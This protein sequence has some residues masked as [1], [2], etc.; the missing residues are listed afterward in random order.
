MLM[1]W[2]YIF[3]AL[4]HWHQNFPLFQPFVGESN[5]NWGIPPENASILWCHQGLPGIEKCR[6]AVG[7]GASTCGLAN[8]VD[9][10]CWPEEPGVLKEKLFWHPLTAGV[11]E[12]IVLWLIELLLWDEPPELFGAG[13]LWCVWLAVNRGGWLPAVTPGVC[14]AA[15][16]CGLWLV[17]C[18]TAGGRLLT[19][20][21]G[22]ILGPVWLATTVCVICDPL[23]A[24]LWGVPPG[25]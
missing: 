23:V 6:L 18:P 16:N 3:L 10:T 9:P 13:C 25:L 5:G 24:D 7:T 22:V 21:G 2:S 12:F 1:H 11:L 15:A 17:M 4:T 8:L 14:W 20:G 19:G